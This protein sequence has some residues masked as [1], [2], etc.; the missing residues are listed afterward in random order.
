MVELEEELLERRELVLELEETLALESV[1]RDGVRAEEVSLTRR[2][3]RSISLKYSGLSSLTGM[4]ASFFCFLGN[5]SSGISSSSIS[6]SVLYLGSMKKSI[7][8]MKSL[9]LPNIFLDLVP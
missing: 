9:C 3:W 8:C 2:S 6:I 1:K 5:S 7:S 4:I